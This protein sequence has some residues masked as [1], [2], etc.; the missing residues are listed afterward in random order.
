VR[1]AEAA[2]NDHEP[3]LRMGP[4]VVAGDFNSNAIWNSLT[5]DGHARLVQQLDALGL[6]SAYHAHGDEAHGAETRS[7]YFEHRKTDRPFHIDYVFVPK[8]WTQLF[9]F[10]LGEPG[11]WLHLSDHVP[12]VVQVPDRDDGADQTEHP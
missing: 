9:G 3:L 5:R 10:E 1:S 6:V 8:T 2:V 7:T 11:Q 12:V 4:C